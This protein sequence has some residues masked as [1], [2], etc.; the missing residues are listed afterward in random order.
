MLNKHTIEN[1]CGNRMQMQTKK[2]IRVLDDGAKKAISTRI[3]I[4]M[5]CYLLTCIFKKDAANRSVVFFLQLTE[6]G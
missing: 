1:Q 2:M 4:A 5:L 6:N 3:E